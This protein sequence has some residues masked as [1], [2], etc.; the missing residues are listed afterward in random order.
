MANLPA[1]QTN[2]FSF[3]PGVLSLVAITNGVG[4]T[5]EADLV[6]VG[7]VRSGG[8]FAVNRTR[9][10][11]QQGSPQALAIQYVTAESAELTVNGIEWDLDNLRLA[12]G[13]GEMTVGPP[14]DLQFGGDLNIVQAAVMFVHVMPSGSTITIRLWSAQGSG[15]VSVTFGDDIHEIPYA[16][17]A[18]DSNNEWSI[19]GATIGTTLTSGKRLFKITKEV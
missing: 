2:N 10:E 12:F 16:F 7:G 19:S 18:L 17:R 11:V 8:S 6:D 4:N 5:I 14:I 9:L 1:Y 3:G 15:E 13:A